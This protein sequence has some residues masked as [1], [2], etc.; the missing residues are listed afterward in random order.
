MTNGLFGGCTHLRARRA[1]LASCGE[2]SLA[3]RASSSRARSRTDTRLSVMDAA[4]SLVA[5]A[6]PSAAAAASQHPPPPP[7][8]LLLLL[9]LLLLRLAAARPRR[10]TRLTLGDNSAA[11]EPTS[12]HAV[13]TVRSKLAPRGKKK[14]APRTRQDPQALFSPSNPSN[15]RKVT[16]LV[17]WRG[18]QTSADTSVTRSGHNGL[19]IEQAA[20]PTLFCFHAQ[21]SRSKF[22]PLGNLAKPLQESDI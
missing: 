9:L 10:H 20:K 8:R 4:G 12:A 22:G 5:P 6:R 14:G 17:G 18:I 13:I 16:E 21:L 15:S 3:A 11:T 2:A 1:L 7:P 19:H